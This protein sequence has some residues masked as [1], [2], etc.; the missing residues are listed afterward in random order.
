[1][2]KDKESEIINKIKKELD[3][4]LALNKKDKGE[5][6][7]IIS[8]LEKYH[9]EFLSGLIVEDVFKSKMFDK[10]FNYDSSTF[11]IDFWIDPENKGI[12]KIIIQNKTGP[13]NEKFSFFHDIGIESFG[14][15]KQINITIPKYLSA[16]NEEIANLAKGTTNVFYTAINKYVEDKI[17]SLSSELS[18]SLY[19]QVKEAFGNYGKPQLANDFLFAVIDSRKN[20]GIYIPDNKAKFYLRKIGE[21]ISTSGKSAAEYTLIHFITEQKFTEM[22]AAEAVKSGGPISINL[23]SA[24]Y[25][26]SKNQFLIAEEAFAGDTKFTV[27]PIKREGKRLLVAWYPTK[28]AED[29]NKILKNEIERL[30]Q[31]FD[32]N[33]SSLKELFKNIRQVDL[34]T[35]FKLLEWGKFAAEMLGSSFILSK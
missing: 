4:Y 5:V 17:T 7:E 35:I 20:S 28:N 31:I 16:K 18:K 21:N 1:M 22:F 33:N 19:S 34:K 14:L 13:S 23:D 8:M 10:T 6:T 25:I 24:N 15:V 3:E 9:L 27:Y 26:G 32:D 2:E 30:T 29:I 11:F 12:A